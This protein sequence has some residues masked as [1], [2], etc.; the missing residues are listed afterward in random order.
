MSRFTADPM[1]FQGKAVFIIGGGPS[2]KGFNWNVLRSKNTIGCNTAFELGED[3]CKYCFFGDI[4]FLN[5]NRWDLKKYKGK[6]ITNFPGL[7]DSTCEWLHTMRRLPSGL[8]S[9]PD[10]LAWNSNSGAAAIN[11][12]LLLGARTVYLLGFDNGPHDSQLNWHDKTAFRGT[13]VGYDRHREGL[14]TVARLYPEIFPGT[15][16]IN[17]NPFSRLE[18]FP[19]KTFK[20]YPHINTNLINS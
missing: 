9:E 4:Q 3:V 20:K 13:V 10:A 6:L 1:T 16:V 8:S 5:K 14:N 12:A 18:C 7:Q 2:L 11:L 19:K 15:E 17:L